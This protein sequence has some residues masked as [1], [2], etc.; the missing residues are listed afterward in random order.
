MAAARGLHGDSHCHPVGNPRKAPPP[1]CRPPRPPV[2]LPPSR[3]RR[4]RASA[5]YRHR[6]AQIFALP[7]ASS[8]IWTATMPW[9]RACARIRALPLAGQP[10]ASVTA[11]DRQA[12]RHRPASPAAAAAGRPPPRSG[13]HRLSRAVRLCSQAEPPY[14]AH[15]PKPRGAEAI[16]RGGSSG[17]SPYREPHPACGFYRVAGYS[18]ARR[19]MPRAGRPATPDVGRQ[20]RGAAAP[21]RVGPPQFLTSSGAGCQTWW[22]A[23]GLAR[24]AAVAADSPCFRESGVRAVNVPGE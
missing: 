14:T 4:S 7:C 20:S 2:L 21:A 1:G 18:T 13:G 17:Q 12:A 11:C 8:L 15:R 9:T 5:A 22:L 23:K 19:A 3:S 24:I 16:S 10:A 6:L